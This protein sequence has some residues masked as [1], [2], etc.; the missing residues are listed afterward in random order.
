MN[1]KNASKVI[2]LIMLM[3][4]PQAKVFASGNEGAVNFALR[5]GTW[6]D[7]YTNSPSAN[8]QQWLRDHFWR[9]QTTSPYF[10]SR[11]SWYQNAW[12]YLDLYGI[13]VNSV[14]VAQHPEWILK[15]S[16][17][18]FLYVPFAC[19]G[20]TCTQ[21]AAD[22]GNAQFR[23][24]WISNARTILAKG[25]KG[26][27]IDDVNLAFRV[28]NASGTFVAPVD[29][30]TN[31]AMN[32]TNWMKYMAD[33]TKAI[34]TAFPG[35]EITHNSIWYAGDTQRDN[36]PYVIQEIQSADYIICERGVSDAGLTGG[37]GS[38]SLN[39][40]FAFVDHVHALGK[41]VGFD[42]YKLNGEY[43]LAGYFM[44]SN[45]GDSE[46]DQSMNPD[47]WW[48][49]YEVN[50]GTAQGARYTWSN[51]LRRDFSNGLVLMNPPQAAT[52]TITLPHSFQRIN[53]TTV[54]Q[55]T[56]AAGQGAVLLGTNAQTIVP[57]VRIDT[58]AGAPGEFSADQYSNG[59]SVASFSQAVDVTGVANAAPAG[60]YQ[61]KRTSQGSPFSYAIPALETGHV[62]TVRL[63]FADDLSTA[64]G[65]RVFNVSINGQAALTNFDIFAN[66][67]KVRKAVVKQFAQAA[68]VNGE[69]VIQFTPGSK[70]SALIS[71]IEVIE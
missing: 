33:F 1:F 13:P 55:V 28:G 19:N 49:G 36:N 47:N 54:S 52:V 59:G 45:G 40:L 35:I 8:S 61:S 16:S 37:T 6:F 7:K 68:D 20:T 5:S 48:A 34:R 31:A 50:L 67:G 29:M 42:E 57:S 3:I 14:L 65:Q 43:G 62:Y 60:V 2:A 39:A 41:Q 66:A 9:L 21:Y 22:P 10:D 71:G 4:A 26:L 69:I 58:G 70:G 46:I 17:G 11:L 18:K 64:A 27:W 53:G 32:L 44:I 30:R 38:W 24:Y 23:A 63:H 56:L 51:V 25:Y 12:V 15:D